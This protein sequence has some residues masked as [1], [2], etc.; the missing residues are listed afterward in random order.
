[1][2]KKTIDQVD[3][4]GKRVLMRVD[5]NVPLNDRQGVIDDRRIVSALPTITSVLERKG[6]LITMTYDVRR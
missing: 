1:M 5:F 4:A 6:K 3:V 2:A